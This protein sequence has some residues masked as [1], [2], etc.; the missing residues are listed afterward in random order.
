MK[1]KNGKVRAD[2]IIDVMLTSEFMRCLVKRTV[3]LINEKCDNSP[4]PERKSVRIP[5]RSSKNTASQRTGTLR[6]NA[7]GYGITVYTDSV[8]KG[9]KPSIGRNT[10]FS[11]LRRDGYL[12]SPGSPKYNLPLKKALDAGLMTVVKKPWYN[13]RIGTTEVQSAHITQKGAEFFYDKYVLS[14]DTK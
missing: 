8:L 7:N 5:S 9:C 10:F 4:E 6:M 1:R 11:L 2:D 3:A 12:G 14:H 13:A